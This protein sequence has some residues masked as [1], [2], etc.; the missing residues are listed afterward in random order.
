MSAGEKPSIPAPA[1]PLRMLYAVA[2]LALYACF[3]AWLALSDHSWA[4]VLIAIAAAV[5]SVASAMLKPWSRFLVYALCASFIAAWGYS[6]YRSYR[7]GLFHLL[8][9][10]QLA[11][12]LAPD[13]LMVGL[14][15]YCSYAVYANFR[16]R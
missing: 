3:A 16:Q 7:V 15:V 14:I 2:L 12:F 5:A 10:G 11:R 9:P 4:Y 8:S 6:V 1:T 13:I